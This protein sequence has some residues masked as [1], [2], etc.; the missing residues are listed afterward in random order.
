MKEWA[1][2]FII[3]TIIY[4]VIKAVIERKQGG[5]TRKRQRKH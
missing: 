5:W 3:G 4:Q 1:A 2:G